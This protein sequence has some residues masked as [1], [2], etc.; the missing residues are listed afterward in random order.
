M[1]NVPKDAGNSKH[2]QCPAGCNVM[3]VNE[4]GVIIELELEQTNT[5]TVARL[6]SQ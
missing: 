3:G 2:L 1:A 5:V 6:L 4:H